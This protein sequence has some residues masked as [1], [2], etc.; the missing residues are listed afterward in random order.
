MSQIIYA[1]QF[2]G[3]AGPVGDSPTLLKAATSAPSCSITS[4]VG[5]DGVAGSIQ[6]VGGG[7]ATFESEVEITGDTSFPEKGSITFGEGHSLRFTTVGAGHIA[8][9]ADPGLKHGTVMWR[10]ESGQGRFEGATGLITSNFTL[11]E[12]GEVTDNQFGVIFAQ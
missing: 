12:R 7:Q 2:Q 11:G 8:A 4:V 3:Q 5:S 1:M 9:S 6:P 10:I